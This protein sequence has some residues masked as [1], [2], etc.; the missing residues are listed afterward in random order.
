MFCMRLRGA[1]SVDWSLLTSSQ[2]AKPV[3][4][5]GGGSPQTCPVAC[6]AAK[7]IS[8]PAVTRWSIV[9]HSHHSAAAIG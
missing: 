4:A 6:L 5:Q 9:S 3:W 8:F 2:G 1:E 7:A